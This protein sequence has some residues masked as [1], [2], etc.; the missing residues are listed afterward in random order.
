MVPPV[1]TP[2]FQYFLSIL[3]ALMYLSKTSLAHFLAA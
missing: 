2:L 1:N 3:N